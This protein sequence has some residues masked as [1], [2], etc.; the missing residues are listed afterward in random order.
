MTAR[1]TRSEIMDDPE[2]DGAE[3]AR[4]FRF[5]RWIN[6]RMCGADGL[7]RPLRAQRNEFGDA[8][9]ILDVGTGCADIPLAAV[10]WGR[11]HGVAVRVVGVDNLQASLDDARREVDLAATRKARN[12]SDAASDRAMVAASGPTPSALRHLIELVQ[13]DAFELERRFSPRSFDVVHAGMFLHHFEESQ[14][15][16]LLR[17]MGALAR[18]MVVWNDL[19]RDAWSRVGVRVLTLPLPRVVRHDAV[20][21]VDKGFLVRDIRD[22]IGRAGLREPRIA[23]WRWAGRFSASIPIS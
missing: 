13:I 4:A 14:I 19:S 2:T 3:I 16:Q 18:R 15:V 7:L 10:E 12:R 17:I 1:P 5:I 6:R 11:R 23:R 20:L 9:S 21:S 22:L 8:L